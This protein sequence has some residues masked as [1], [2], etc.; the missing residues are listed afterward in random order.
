ME[1][2]EVSQKKLDAMLEK[3]RIIANTTQKYVKIE[4]TPG[5]QVWVKKYYDREGNEVK[6]PL[7]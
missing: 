6:N 2:S 5:H 4:D 7:R 1:L 3:M